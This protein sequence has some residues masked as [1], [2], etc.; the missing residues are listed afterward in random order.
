MWCVWN[1]PNGRSVRIAA[2]TRSLT[3]FAVR[4]T[5]NSRGPSVMQRLYIRSLPGFC[6]D[7]RRFYDLTFE[8]AAADIHPDRLAVGNRGAAGVSVDP[9][10]RDAHFQCPGKRSPSRPPHP[11][12]TTQARQG[13]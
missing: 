5:L 13:V 4:S 8:A 1:L 3:G 7:E 2:R 11:G 9:R 6:L 10:K 12:V